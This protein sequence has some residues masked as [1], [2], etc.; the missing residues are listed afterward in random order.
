MAWCEHFGSAGPKNRCT[1][2]NHCDD[3]YITVRWPGENNAAGTPSPQ[4]SG[5]SVGER[6][7][8][9]RGGGRERERGA[10]DRIKKSGPQLES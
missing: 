2:T 1:T 6:E 10:Q 8:K 9:E 7:R 3:H 4:P 5:R